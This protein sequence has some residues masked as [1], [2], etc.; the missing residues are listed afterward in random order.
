MQAKDFPLSI[1][2]NGNFFRTSTFLVFTSLLTGT[3]S[4]SISADPI[5][6]E[7]S[8]FY[9]RLKR[10]YKADFPQVMLSFAVPQTPD[11][12]INSGSITSINGTFPLVYTP[13][14][15]LFIPY[16]ASLKSDRGMI[17][18][19]VAGDAS[20]CAI[21]M[22]VRAKMPK[23]EY[24]QSQLL[25]MINQMDGMLDTLNGFPL[26]YFRNKL[27]GITFEFEQEGDYWVD[28]RLKAHKLIL[29]LSIEDIKSLNEISFATK[30]K[31]IS[32]WIAM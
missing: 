14:Q 5:S 10:V 23:V 26:K 2:F 9:D 12:K 22:Q 13:S 28:G 16:D 27:D 32:P 21:T 3:Y 29:H 8:G 15:Q 1:S 20:Q 4:S 24:K 30:A 25:S 31:V 17:N 7:Y 11:C 18:L 19:V 6:L